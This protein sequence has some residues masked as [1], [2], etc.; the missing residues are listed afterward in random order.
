MLLSKSNNEYILKLD[1]HAASLRK[2]HTHHMYLLF[3]S[4]IYEQCCKFGRIMH[5]LA[6]LRSLTPAETVNKNIP[7]TNLQ[8]SLSLLLE[9]DIV[10]SQITV[11]NHCL[12]HTVSR[13][14]FLCKDAEH[15]RWMRGVPA[16]AQGWLLVSLRPGS[17][18]WRHPRPMGWDSSRMRVSLAVMAPLRWDEACTVHCRVDYLLL[19]GR[20]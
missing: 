13:R 19:V 15:S 5:E 2:C 20:G 3:K 1:Y 4:T 9:C 18:R 17:P 8:F 7:Y 14:L 11:S 10:H 12:S 16:T 6:S